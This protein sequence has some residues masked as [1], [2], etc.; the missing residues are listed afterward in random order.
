ML[1]RRFALALLAA[2]ATWLAAC[3]QESSGTKTAAPATATADEDRK[4]VV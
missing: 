4:S 3:S 1:N 2:P